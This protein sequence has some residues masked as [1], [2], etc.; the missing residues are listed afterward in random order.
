MAR[1]DKIGQ[2]HAITAGLSRADGIEETR[3]DDGQLLF[4]P[5]GERQKFIERLGS[6]IAPAAFRRRAQNQVGVFVERHVGILSVYLGGRRD[7]NQLLFFAGGFQYQLRTVHV[8]LDR[9]DGAF[10]N[11]SHAH[12]GGEGA[13]S[14]RPHP[15]VRP[16]VGGF[17]W[18]RGDIA[19]RGTFQVT[20]VFHAA[21]GKIVQQN[22]SI[23][24][25]Q[26]TLGQM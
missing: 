11:E 19:V 26:Q 25:F 5:I 18:R 16:A 14:R 3:H 23:T 21:G 13:P 2:H 6:G 8:G 10:D 24:V 4:L 12:G 15:P 9:A 17:R 7:Q 1:L 20:D 22:D